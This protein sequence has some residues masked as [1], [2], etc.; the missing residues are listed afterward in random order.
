MAGPV[1]EGCGMNET[2]L[3]PV[4]GERSKTV[5]FGKSGTIVINFD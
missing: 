2:P 3:H 4:L 1:L 5:V